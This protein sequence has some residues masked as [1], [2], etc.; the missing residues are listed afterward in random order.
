[1]LGI[2]LVGLGMRSMQ[3]KHYFEE[4]FY[5]NSRHRLQDPTDTR[6]YGVEKYTDPHHTS[7]RSLPFLSNGFP[8]HIHNKCKR[9]GGDMAA[10]IG[11]AT[12]VLVTGVAVFFFKQKTAY[13][14]LA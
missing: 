7:A 14:I 6:K 2:Q 1:M 9:Q 13:E 10:S 3:N 12:S 4:L 5:L 8:I 11:S